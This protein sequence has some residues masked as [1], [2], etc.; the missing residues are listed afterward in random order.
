MGD[1]GGLQGSMIYEFSSGEFC[2]P[3][4]TAMH[5]QIHMLVKPIKTDKRAATHPG[6]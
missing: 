1:Y 4:R 5:I 3:K 2:C 6:C